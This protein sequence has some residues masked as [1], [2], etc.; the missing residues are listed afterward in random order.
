MQPIST[1]QGGCGGSR[2]HAAVAAMQPIEAIANEASVRGMARPEA[3]M[4][5]P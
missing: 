1:T 3:N 2:A 4:S 5:I